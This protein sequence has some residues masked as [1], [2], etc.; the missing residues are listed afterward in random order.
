MKHNAL[1]S[2]HTF[3]NNDQ[4][5]RIELATPISQVE[6]YADRAPGPVPAAAKLIALLDAAK[7]AVV[8]ARPA[9]PAP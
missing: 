9:D 7:A 3:I 2:T 5:L 1:P 4:R 6:R 8:A